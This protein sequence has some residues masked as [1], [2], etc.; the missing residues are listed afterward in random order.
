MKIQ[1]IRKLIA[2]G[3]FLLKVATPSLAVTT[4][5][6]AVTTSILAVATL[7]MATVSLAD[8]QAVL[9]QPSMVVVE[10]NA[11]SREN[12]KNEIGF[13][14]QS[15]R[16][17]GYVIVQGSFVDGQYD[18]SVQSLSDQ[19]K[20]AAQ[21]TYF[22]KALNLAILKVNG[23]SLPPLVFSSDPVASEIPLWLA[24]LDA[25]SNIT[26]EARDS[27]KVHPFNSIVVNGCSEFRGLLWKNNK[28]ILGMKSILSLL[29]SRNVKVS[30]AR[31]TCHS[32]VS[33]AQFAA[34][35]A[36]REAQ[37]ARR[38]A[39]IAQ[40]LVEKLEM[41]LA[42][43][44][45][46]NSELMK[47]LNDTRRRTE[48]ALRIAK[49]AEKKAQ[50]ITLPQPS[51]LGANLSNQLRE[52]RIETQQHFDQIMKDQKVAAASRETLMLMLGLL[53]TV[54]IIGLSFIVIRNNTRQKVLADKQ[55]DILVKAR[56]KTVLPTVHSETSFAEYVLDGKD[57][58][59]IRYLL[60]ISGDQMATSDGIIIGRNP[61]DSPYIVNHADVSRRHAR[62]K[63]MKDRAFI[64]DLGS[65]NGTSVNG[66]AIDDK[67]PV[68][69]SSGDQIIIG[70]VVMKLRVL[71]G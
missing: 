46:N 56:P 17:N 45:E 57:E 66:Q 24:S 42:Q 71:N 8:P 54:L 27:T 63:L 12:S 15:D 32:S 30:I 22:D 60:R 7:L 11:S 21:L 48:T 23:L 59:G 62:L 4:S 10:I 5:I 9:L 34:Q 36:L 58:N 25:L 13:V 61:K 49:S 28:T 6:L 3:T 29:Q 40:R 19:T 41:Q 38:E 70:S 51:I 43:S 55:P 2:V 50:L 67:G 26:L 39:A 47:I 68:S 20:L 33:A 35:G 44:K 64:E 16:Y 18:I 14:V 65:T 37:S 52:G 53:I 1:I 31:D 69:V